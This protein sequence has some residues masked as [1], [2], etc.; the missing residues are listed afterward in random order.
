[1]IKGVNGPPSVNEGD[2]V[3]MTCRYDLGRDLLYSMK[4]FKEGSG[5]IF[6]YVPT[7]EPSIK[8]F[9]A[10]GIDIKVSLLPY[11]VQNIIDP[12]GRPQTRPV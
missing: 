12:R 11:I 9:Q 10:K 6:R 3:T 4:W 1:M 2:T 5:E 8:V 7:D